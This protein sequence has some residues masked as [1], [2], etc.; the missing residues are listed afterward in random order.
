MTNMTFNT[1]IE[2]IVLSDG[3]PLES[4]YLP[5]TI[6]QYNIIEYL[7]LLP[8]NIFQLISGLNYY[9]YQLKSSLNQGYDLKIINT[10]DWHI[11]K[12]GFNKIT[13]IKLFF[14]NGKSKEQ[15]KILKELI[16]IDEKF[17]F[18]CFYKHNASVYHSN[19]VGSPFDFLDK[20]RDIE[21][22]ILESFNLK[23]KKFDFSLP[24]GFRELLK[25]DLF[26]PVRNNIYTINNCIG[27]FYF[28]PNFTRKEH[29]IVTAKAIKDG[30]TF[31]RQ[32]IFIHQLRNLDLLTKIAYKENIIS[33]IS[34]VEPELAPLILVAPFHNP[35][36]KTNSVELDYSLT[37]EQTSNYTIEADMRKV[38]EIKALAAMKFHKLRVDYLDDLSYLH[39][40]FCFSPSLRLPIKGKSIYRELSFFGPIS[41]KNSTEANARKKLLKTINNFGKKFTALTISPK[42]QSDL[43]FRNSQIVAISDL[44]VEWMNINDIP[45]SF[46][47]DVCRIPETSLH[48]LM[49]H[50]VTNQNFKFSINKDILE[51][52]LVILGSHDKNFALWHTQVISLQEKLKFHVSFCHKLDDV[53]DAVMKY[54][55]HLIIFDCH[56]GIDLDSNSTYLFIGNEKLDSR[57]IV[58]NDIVAPLV[59]LS[60]CG[61][62]PTYGTMNPIA[63]AFFEAGALSVTSTFLPISID[64]GSILYL[65]LLYNLHHAS[66]NIIHKNWLEF[67]SY[68]IRTST[69]NDAYKSAFKK[70]TSINITDFHS[71]NTSSLVESLQFNKRRQLYQSL[72][73]KISQMAKNDREYYTTV[74][75]E[76]LLYTNLGRSDLILFDN[77]NKEYQLKNIHSVEG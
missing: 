25:F 6:F 13:R 40:S 38:S 33:K 34:G 41:F 50:Y 20:M 36:F 57:Y 29:H 2:F 58:D 54:K 5:P 7:K 44:P 48:S 28:S 17:S 3:S 37:L 46:T 72:N 53:K 24:V 19:I 1:Q 77:W 21:Q 39:S 65:R 23:N 55:P 67:V 74:I 76:Y 14:I 35:D 51:N 61:T 62:A 73:K 11:Y 31:N 10:K 18:F 68:V 52:T 15:L 12:N 69:I 22:L 64:G 9:D 45:L 30:S 43:K 63:N 75:P 26:M 70:N 32:E 56:G 60:A 42:L 49:S 16:Q 66:N 47:H 59:F 27:N 4:V 8:K 71:A